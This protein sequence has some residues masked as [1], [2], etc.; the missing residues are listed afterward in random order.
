MSALAPA[1]SQTAQYDVD[2]PPVHDRHVD[3]RQV[4]RH[5]QHDRRD[6]QR[7]DD[8]RRSGPA[9]TAAAGRTA[10]SRRSSRPTIW[11]A[12]DPN[13]MTSVLPQV[14]VDVDPVPGRREL[15]QVE[16]VRPQRHRLAQRV[17]RRRDRR[18]EH[19][20]QRPEADDE[21]EQQRRARGGR[22]SSSAT[23]R[24]RQSALDRIDRSVEDVDPGASAGA[25]RSSVM[26]SVLQRR[27]SQ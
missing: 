2:Q 18:L 20:Q 22:A 19:P 25:R 8:Q 10:R 26:T 7:R 13:A 21:Q 16:A 4:Q 12:H 11:T 6:E 17:L 24:C 3:D 5:E 23:R 14:A 15:R 27:V 9:R 1:G